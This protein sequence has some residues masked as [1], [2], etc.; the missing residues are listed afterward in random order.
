MACGQYPENFSFPATH[1]SLLG[2]QWKEGAIEI[3]PNQF[4]ALPFSAGKK[5]IKKHFELNHQAIWA[6]C[7]GCR[8]SEML[9][10]CLLPGRANEVLAMSRLRL[11]APV[12]LLTNHTTLRAHLHKLGHTEW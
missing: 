3:P 6:A 8:Q 10:G 12:G 11:R 2:H 4:T 7:T 9:M 1:F 5:L